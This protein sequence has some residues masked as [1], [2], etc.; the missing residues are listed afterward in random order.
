M[1]S[2][3]LSLSFLQ[4]EKTLKAKVEA[5]QQEQ[6]TDFL[7]NGQQFIEYIQMQWNNLQM[8]KELEKAE[9]VNHLNKMV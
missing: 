5:W 3:L 1:V 7:V 8:E 6:G 9:R 2:W 4:L